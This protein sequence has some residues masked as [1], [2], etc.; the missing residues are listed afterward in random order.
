MYIFEVVE[1]INSLSLYGKVS[2]EIANPPEEREMYY[3]QIAKLPVLQYC[4]KIMVQILYVSTLI[5]QMVLSIR[6]KLKKK[7]LL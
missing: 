4:V 1:Q 5:V 3:I 7:K 2:T 6:F